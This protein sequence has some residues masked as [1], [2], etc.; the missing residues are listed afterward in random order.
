MLSDNDIQE[1]IDDVK[2]LSSKS[3]SGIVPT[4]KDGKRH[5]GYELEIIS[6]LGKKYIIR[7]RV[8][9][10]NVFDFSVILMYQQECGKLYIL[11]RYNGSSHSHRNKIEK[12]RLRGFHMHLATERYQKAGYDIDGYAEST[13]SY[14]NWHD[15]LSKMI[16]D[17]NFKLDKSLLSSFDR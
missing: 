8:N 11:R 6:Q 17:C 13:N 10:I 12:D 9:T 15:A 16:A 5:K 14:T 2:P 1:L 4:A 7:V 3:V